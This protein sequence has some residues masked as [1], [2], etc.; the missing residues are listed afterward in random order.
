MTGDPTGKQKASGET[1]SSN[2]QPPPENNTTSQS[3][4]A[5]EAHTQAEDPSQDKAQ[6][7][8]ALFMTFLSRV[9]T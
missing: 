2:V 9:H 5:Q 8:T 6:G 3:A 4:G 1:E 7:S